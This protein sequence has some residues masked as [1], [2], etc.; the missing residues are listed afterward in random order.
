MASGRR[1][2]VFNPNER[3]IST[4]QVRTQKM[5][6][7]MEAEMLRYMLD[8]YGDEDVVGGGVITEPSSVETP[9]RA[10]ILNG[11]LVR[12]DLGTYNLLIDPGY[13]AVMAPD[14]AAEESNYKTVREAGVSVLGALA[15]TANVSGSARLDVIECQIASAQ[16]TT[17]EIRDVFNQP[18][19]VFVPTSVTKTQQGK[20]VYRVRA[21]T[22]GVG[23]PGAVAGWLPLC[24]AYVPNG[25][26]NNGAITF[27][28]VRPLISDRTRSPF[29][30]TAQ[31]PETIQQWAVVND[32]DFASQARLTGVIMSSLAGRR[33]GGN[34]YR[35]TPGTDN[36]WVD[37]LDVA[38]QSAGF[39]MPASGLVY[40]YLC[41]P[42]GLP[43]WTRY[44]TA[45]LPRA[46]NGIYV[47]STVSPYTNGKPSANLP[48]PTSIVGAS[49][50]FISP[51]GAA[52]CV[53][54]FHVSS[55]T[56]H[57]LTIDGKAHW[58]R[59]GLG[60]TS[61]PDGIALSA[62]AR[63]LTTSVFTIAPGVHFP[64]NAKAIWCN[65]TAS[66]NISANTTP[67]VANGS[68]EIRAP[69]TNSVIAVVPG[70]S[71]TFQANA[72]A[73]TGARFSSG[74][75]RIPLIPDYPASSN[76]TSRQLGWRLEA[77]GGF[78]GINAA[79]LY[80]SGWEL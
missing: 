46:P 65:F 31:L 42:F 71:M 28:D 19:N 8:V 30:L 77:S 36:Q 25:A 12:P 6:G 10:E 38:N 60:S 55:T 54:A 26:A 2:Q 75:M 76:P 27:W 72:S 5:I 39:A 63:A 62:G 78:S 73:L 1:E 57:G 64:A 68:V 43:R 34:V 14:A 49:G 11:L 59:T 16:N 51:N 40:L 41:T 20:L 80:V 29:M 52:V 7:Y 17:Q 47:L 35:G 66:L 44:S 45:G 67:T 15:I 23:F 3:V 69:S 18:S 21:G 53:A 13:V 50:Q 58:I 22:A 24:V 61:A 9:L 4:D 48:L 70:N 56:M 79:T 74:L 32:R 37:L 33:V